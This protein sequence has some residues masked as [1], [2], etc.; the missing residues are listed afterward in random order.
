MQSSFTRSVPARL[1]TLSFALF[2]F[3][4]C[5]D[6]EHTPHEDTGSGTTG[7]PDETEGSETSVDALEI[8]GGWVEEYPGGMTTHTITDA[9]WTQASDFGVFAYALETF[10]NEERWVVGRSDD[11]DTYSRFDWT[12][13]GDDELHVCTAVFGVETLEEA[14]D[15]PQADADDLDVGCGG[16]PWSHLQPE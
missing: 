14:A 12:W 4:G 10:D 6:D 16:F 13:D 7:H 15:A 5:D 1:A 2:I 8:V 3:V 11:D 9:S